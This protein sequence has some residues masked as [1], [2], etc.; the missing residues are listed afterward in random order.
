MGHI[1]QYKNKFFLLLKTKPHICAASVLLIRTQITPS[2]AD[3][4]LF[5]FIKLSC[6]WHVHVS[7]AILRIAMKMVFIRRGE[8][9]V[10]SIRE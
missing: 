4:G 10:R 3:K 9:G 8:K 5:F 6:R 7:F 2:P 1:C